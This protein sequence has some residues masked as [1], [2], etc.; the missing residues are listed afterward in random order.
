MSLG[1]LNKDGLIVILGM[2][3]SIVGLAVATA[4]VIFG[5][6]AL[7]LLLVKFLPFFN[8]L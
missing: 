4:V 6:K 2:V 1:L 3:V 8:F 7:K 5:L